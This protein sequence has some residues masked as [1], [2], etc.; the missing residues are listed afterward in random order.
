MTSG[1]ESMR[2]PRLRLCERCW[3]LI[4]PGTACQVFRHKDP[5]RPYLPAL[6]SFQHLADDR[7]C[8]ALDRQIAS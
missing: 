5:D 6:L 8:V 7:C 4:S 3:R 1:G 2:N